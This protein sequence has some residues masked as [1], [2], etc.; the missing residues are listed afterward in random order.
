MPGRRRAAT[1]PPPSSSPCPCSA[2]TKQPLPPAAG[3]SSRPL[4][5]RPRRPPRPRPR[6]RRSQALR[7]GRPLPDPQTGHRH[8]GEGLRGWGSH[9]SA[10]SVWGLSAQE[11]LQKADVW[12]LNPEGEIM[13]GVKL[14]DQ[15][16]LDRPPKPSPS[17]ASPSPNTDHGTSASRTATWKAAPTRRCRRKSL[18]RATWCWSSRRSGDVLPGQCIVGECGGADRPWRDDWRGAAGGFG[19]GGQV[20]HG[21]VPWQ[22]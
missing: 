22:D 6:P 19:V 2:S 7:P 4:P 21:T 3:W 9:T 11:Y 1:G 5:G 10:A 15:Q 12:P 13:L 20:E 14:E 8:R 18:L 17:P 16:A